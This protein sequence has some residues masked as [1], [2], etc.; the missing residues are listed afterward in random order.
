MW[1]SERSRDCFLWKPLVF[2]VINV[3]GASHSLL[4]DTAGTAPA[5]GMA[6]PA[7]GLDLLPSLCFVAILE[8]LWVFLAVPW[9]MGPLRVPAVR[10][11]RAALSLHSSLL[12][13]RFVPVPLSNRKI[14]SCS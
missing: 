6:L 10:L 7:R 11:S 14:S 2:W 9:P 3:P 5:A 12:F 1:G 4:A 13:Q 8:L